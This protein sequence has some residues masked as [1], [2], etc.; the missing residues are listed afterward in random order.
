MISSNKLFEILENEE[1]E[2]IY[3]ANSVITSCQF[4]RTGKLLSR[5]TA[6]KNG[7]DQ[8]SQISDSIDKKRSVW[9]DIFTDSVDIHHRG[10]RVN[11][12]G[13]VL[14]KLDVSM[15]KDIYTG[16]VS[17]TKLN[18]TKWKGKKND[19][20]WFQSADELKEGFIYGEFDQM[21]VFRHCGGELPIA[22][23]LEEIVLDDPLYEITK[24]KIDYYSMAYGALKYAMSVSGIDVPI[25]KRKCRGSCSC[26]KFYTDNPE[27]IDKM[28]QPFLDD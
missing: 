15:L 10:S 9:F 22:K 23:H 8:S 20:R 13:P 27:E 4:L 24:G 11:V 7:Y 1:V 6:S 17:V 14:F 18:P 3:H 26:D 19:Q 2:Y 5:G 28:F 12:Y 25:I 16:S 21:I